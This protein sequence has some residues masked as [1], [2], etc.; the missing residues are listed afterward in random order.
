[1]CWGQDSQQGLKFC[2]LL[3][4]GVYC[5]SLCKKVSA[6]KIAQMHSDLDA[7]C[8]IG[9][10]EEILNTLSGLLMDHFDPVTLMDIDIILAA[11]KATTCPLDPCPSWV[12]K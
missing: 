5:K 2:F 7:S 3:Y 4:S 1:M 6:D 10:A 11:V 9:Q 12:L 8:N